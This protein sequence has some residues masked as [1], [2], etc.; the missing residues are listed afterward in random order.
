MIKGRGCFAL[1]G[2]C[3]LFCLDHA[4]AQTEMTIDGGYAKLD[5][6]LNSLD[7]IQAD[8]AQVVK[9]NRDQEIERS[10]GQLQIKRPG[11]FRWEYK[12]PDVQTLVSDGQR[13]WIYDAELEQ[14]TINRIDASFMGSPAMLLSGQ[15]GLRT[16][17]EIEHV[18]QHADLFVINL[19]LKMAARS[20]F[21]LI[22]VSIRGEQLAG[23]SLTD[24]L[25]QTTSLQFTQFK[26]NPKLSDSQFVFTPPKGVDLVDNTRQAGKVK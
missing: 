18:E 6:L 25:G 15:D 21:K 10:S 24:K 22:Q 11:K 13:L 1:I 19:A 4:I 23:M 9:D 17:F 3:L 7:T 8:F 2:L 16:N 20:D 14:V 26:R 12:N 5:R